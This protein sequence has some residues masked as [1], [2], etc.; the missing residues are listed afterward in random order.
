M[1]VNKIQSECAKIL[2]TLQVTV[3]TNED[4]EKIKER[5]RGAIQK[6]GQLRG[7]AK[8]SRNELCACGSGKKYKNC[9]GKDL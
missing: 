7:Q 8:Q 5:Q 4:L 9:C 6:L 3:T 2:L 1:L